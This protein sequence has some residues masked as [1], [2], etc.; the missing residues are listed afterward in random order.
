MESFLDQ[1]KNI[2]ITYI[3]AG[4]FD[5]LYNFVF[6]LRQIN[7]PWKLCVICID[8]QSVKLCNEKNIDCI[9]FPLS[10]KSTSFTIFG[11]KDYK[12]ITMAKLDVINYVLSNEQV[13]TVIYLD[14]DIH[15]YKDFVPYLKEL[16][17][18]DIYLQSDNGTCD[19]SFNNNRCS[20]FMYINKNNNEIFKLFNYKGFDTS[21]YNGDQDH[22]NLIINTNK[23]IK[24]LQL[25][26]D[27][28]PN[29]KF[30]Y[31]IPKDAYILHYNWMKGHEK[32]KNMSKNKHWF[33][34]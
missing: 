26:R 29:G 10:N 1:D 23:N 9:Y 24:A 4:Y 13:K 2:V 27:L 16:K 14:G 12:D 30:I 33:N 28:F 31:N 7:V 20:G 5:Y 21:K 25:P 18:Y 34:S 6:N 32:K 22:I 15:V 17:Y 11:N 8:E 19:M 3:N